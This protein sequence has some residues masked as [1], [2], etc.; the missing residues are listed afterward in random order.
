MGYTPDYGSYDWQE[1]KTRG[2]RR[3]IYAYRARF[4]VIRRKTTIQ[5][6]KRVAQ[7]TYSVTRI[8]TPLMP[9]DNVGVDRVAL[10]VDGAWVATDWIGANGWGVAWPCRAGSHTFTLSVYDQQDNRAE[11]SVQESVTC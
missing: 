10:E 8:V 3:T 2:A 6:Q 7:T 11:S 9:Q 4:G 1:V 5:Q